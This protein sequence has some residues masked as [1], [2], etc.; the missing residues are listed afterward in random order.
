MGQKGESD[1]CSFSK[2]LKIMFCVLCAYLLTTAVAI[3]LFDIFCHNRYYK[4][5]DAANQ[6]LSE[7]EAARH[8]AKADNLIFYKD[9]DVDVKKCDA[10]C[11]G[12]AAA[13]LFILGASFYIDSFDWHEAELLEE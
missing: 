10:A 7:S 13:I 8:L 2:R 4:E 3:S 1:M 6:C 12:V 9:L 11:A 5:I